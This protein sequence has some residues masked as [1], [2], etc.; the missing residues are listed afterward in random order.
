MVGHTIKVSIQNV[1][2][3][4]DNVHTFLEWCWMNTVDNIFIGEPWRSGDIQEFGDR[5]GT[6]LHDAYT[7]GAGDRHKDSVVGY[8]RKSVAH[9]VTVLHSDRKEIWIEIGEV[10]VAGV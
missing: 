3:G 6:Q 9:C 8:W 5:N 7:L 4:S 1:Y 2:Q 10:K